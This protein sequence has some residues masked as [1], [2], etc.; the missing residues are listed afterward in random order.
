MLDGVEAHHKII[1]RLCYVALGKRVA[2][3]ATEVSC[4]G[5]DCIILQIQI[6]KIF[7]RSMPPDLPREAGAF[8]PCLRLLLH[9]LTFYLLPTPLQCT[10]VLEGIQIREY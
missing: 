7:R 5:S 6:K 4:R 9:P 3:M 2:R 10:T 1:P 8:G